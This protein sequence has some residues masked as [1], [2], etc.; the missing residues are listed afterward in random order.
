MAGASERMMGAVTMF[1]LQVNWTAH[2]VNSFVSPVI[3]ERGSFVR[4]SF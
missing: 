3:Q 4:K 2:D 1:I